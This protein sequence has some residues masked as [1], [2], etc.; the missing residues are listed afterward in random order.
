MRLNVA[1]ICVPINWIII[2][3]SN[4]IYHVWGRAIT[5]ASR[6]I[7]ESDFKKHIETYFSQN[8]LIESNAFVNDIFK[9]VTVLGASVNQK[10]S[11]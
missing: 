11:T 10:L 1:C 9:Y 6:A 8:V 5:R 4:G 7:S 2:G 3:L